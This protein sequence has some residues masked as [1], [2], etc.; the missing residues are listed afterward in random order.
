MYEIKFLDG[1]VE[2]FESLVGADLRGAN[3]QEG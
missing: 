2:T 3:L 1:R